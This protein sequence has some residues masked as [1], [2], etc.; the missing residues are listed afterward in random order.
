MSSPDARPH[1]RLATPDD[2]PACAAIYAPYVMDTAISFELLP[3]DGAEMGARI[4]R[5]IERTP[6]V[7]VEVDGAVRAYAYA[8]RHRERPAY[9]WTV[10]TAVYVD[11]EFTRTGLGRIAMHAVLE[12]LRL[13]G[14]HLVVAGITL[15][16]EASVRLH[17]ALGFERT[18]GFEAIGW[19]HERWHGVVWFSLELGPREVQ[20]AP[21]VPLP[22]L[23]GTAALGAALAG[24]V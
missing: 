22:E 7:V 24:D 8:T 14:A 15:P 10:E 3:P 11:R 16:N 19:K 18:G 6:W 9:D 12:I 4:A 21:L 1:A 20:P 5:T 23:A 2:G 17:E 13:Q